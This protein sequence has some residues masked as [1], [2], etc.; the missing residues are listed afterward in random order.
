MPDKKS[1]ITVALV[2]DDIRIRRAMA[3]IL[4]S[5][6]DCR[7]IGQYRSGEE[8][9]E[10]LPQLAPRVIIMDINLPGI[11][12]VGCVRQLI[13][14][15]VQSQ[16]LMLTVHKESDTIFAALAAGAMGYLVK[17]VRAEVLLEA[18]RDVFGGGA[19][20]TGSIARKVVQA[21]Q[22]RAPQSAAT[23]QL[24]P[25]EREILNLLSQGFL[26]KEIAEELNTSYAT[27]RTHI[28]RIY[29]KLHVH[30]RAQAVARFLSR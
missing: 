19:P 30:S 21:F 23:D 16:I 28:E 4:D 13:A 20:M 26:Y 9:I 10:A 15:R 3:L 17:P 7:C 1:P 5:A 18:V 11:D 22:S 29:T 27:V 24:S 14:R 6:D 12:G 8:A 2:E 25:R